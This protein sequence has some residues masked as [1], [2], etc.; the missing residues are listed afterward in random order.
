[1]AIWLARLK[2]GDTITQKEKDFIEL[3]LGDI[4]S[5]QLLFKNT[6]FTLSKGHETHRFI[7]QRFNKKHFYMRRGVVSKPFLVGQ[8][9][10][11]VYNNRG[12]AIGWEINFETGECYKI[13]KNLIDMGTSLEAFDI[14]LN[15]IEEAIPVFKT[16]EMN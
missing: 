14:D 11:C 1:M 13:N 10:L 5:M 8:H 6:Y 9:I 12:D 15:T 4:T 2:N 16:H 3:P 7:Q